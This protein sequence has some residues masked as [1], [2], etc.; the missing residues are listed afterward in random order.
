MEFFA[1]LIEEMSAYSI[2]LRSPHMHPLV[3]SPIKILTVRMLAQSTKVLVILSLDYLKSELSHF[4]LDLLKMRSTDDVIVVT[5]N[6]DLVSYMN[7][8]P[9][10]VA[11][12]LLDN[13]HLVFPVGICSGGEANYNAFLQTLAVKIKGQPT[14]T[15]EC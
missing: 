11:D 7:R 8:L 2:E 12:I 1:G 10:C 6:I 5:V 15:S 4:E 14:E 3:G 13:R 9:Q